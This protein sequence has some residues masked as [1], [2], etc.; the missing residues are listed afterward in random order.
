MKF[1]IKN[2][3][4]LDIVGDLLVP[5]NSKN[6]AFVEHGHGGYKEE[7]HIQVTEDTLFD[8]G[9]TVV[10]FDATNSIGESGGK[11]EYSN[12]QAHYEDLVDVIEWAKSQ[13]WYIEPFVL[14]GH[15]LGGYSVAQYPEKVKGVFPFAPVVSGKLSLEAAEK[16]HP[17]E[18]KKWKETGWRHSMSESK[19]GTE[20][21]LPWSYMEEKLHHDLL[22][23]AL[24][25]TMP[26]LLVVGE[27]DESCPAD[28]QQM[29][30]ELV[31]GKKEIHVIPGARH[32]FKTPEHLDTLWIW[33]PAYKSN[34]R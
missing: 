4:D 34:Y 2:R 23:Q 8:H 31:P 3:K 11:Y 29:L 7:K 17:E 14:A 6:L 25:L 21:N 22:P 12:M 16:F 5:Q 13:N 30:Y 28:Q 15:S 1:S 26:V 33:G 24:K 9:Y 19:P 27:N 18:T 10:N 20:K 32:V